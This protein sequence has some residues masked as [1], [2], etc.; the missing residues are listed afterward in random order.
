MPCKT[1]RT[2]GEPD[3]PPGS[4]CALPSFRE[5]PMPLYRMSSRAR[6]ALCWTLLGFAGLQIG[7]SVVIDHWLPQWR[8]L[9]YGCRAR[10]L[11]QRTAAATDQ[12][13]TVLVLGSSR[14]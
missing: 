14:T 9:E 7:L 5:R 13:A 11:H 2:T 6:S 8:D 10:Q 1:G 4:G 12:P 3:S